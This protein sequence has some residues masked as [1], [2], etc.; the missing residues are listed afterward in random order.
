[1][2]WVGSMATWPRGTWRERGSGGPTGGY[3]GSG[4]WVGK[5]AWSRDHVSL[6]KATAVAVCGADTGPKS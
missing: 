3:V 6:G 2:E 4:T 5:H 1:M